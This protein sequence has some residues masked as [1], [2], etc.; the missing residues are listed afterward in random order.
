MYCNIFFQIQPS[1]V[2]FASVAYPFNLASLACSCAMSAQQ[3]DNN[4]KLN[5]ES[6][7]RKLTLKGSTWKNV[8]QYIVCQAAAEELKWKSCQFYYCKCSLRD[9]IQAVRSKSESW[10]AES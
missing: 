5:G 7:L 1:N 6:A 8:L 3:L 9:A 10:S 4:A 2:S